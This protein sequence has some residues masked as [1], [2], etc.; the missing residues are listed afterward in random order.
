MSAPHF[1]RAPAV[2]RAS[3]GVTA[4]LTLSAVAVLGCLVWLA[5]GPEDTDASESPLVMAVARQL[6]Q[7]PNGLYGPFGGDNPLVLIHAP[8]YYHLATLA[9]YLLEQAGLEAVTAALV[10]GRSLSFLSLLVTLFLIDRLSRIDNALRRAGWWAAGLF[11][12][13][14]IL[15]GLPVAVRPDSLAVMLQSAGVVL[16]LYALMRERPS[17][18]AVPAAYALFGLALCVKQHYVAAPAVSTVLLLACRG[19]VGLR[20]IAVGMILAPAIVV[21][22]YGAEEVATGGWMSRSILI[23]ASRVPQVHPANWG[24]WRSSCTRW[25]SGRSG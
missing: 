11:A 16:V 22:V 3:A 19:R 21:L 4:V 25:R 1:K 8:L 7:G 24:T 15:G 13:S 10:S 20:S 23:A 18:W 6:V 17:R 9:A 2:A 14:P 12:S 5:C